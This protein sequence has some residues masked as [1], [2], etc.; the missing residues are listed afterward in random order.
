MSEKRKRENEKP[1]C[2]YGGKCYQKNPTHLE[3]YA[4][5]GITCDLYG[6]LDR[7]GVLW[8]GRGGCGKITKID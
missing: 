2:K 3:T 1:A 5:P 4:H 6:Q 8:V 7:D